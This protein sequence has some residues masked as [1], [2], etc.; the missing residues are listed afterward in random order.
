MSGLDG[1]GPQGDG[2][3][4]GRGLGKCNDDKDTAQNENPLRGIGRGGEPRGGGRGSGQGGGGGRGRGQGGGGGQGRGQGGG[5]GQ[6]QGRGGRGRD[7]R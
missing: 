7:N 6:G 4:T 3:R 5:G 1:K 2:P